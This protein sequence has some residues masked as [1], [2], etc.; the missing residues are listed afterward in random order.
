MADNEK[1]GIRDWLQLL[2]A[3]AWLLVFVK[4]PQMVFAITLLV[5]GGVFIAFNAMIFWATVVHKGE[6]PAVAPIFGGI[7]AGI[8]VAILPLAGGWKWAW[9][10]LLLDW[11]GLPMFL[12]YLVVR[13]SKV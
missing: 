2:A 12:Y 3:I 1:F 10:P 5:I 13:R 9:I 11:G 6:A 4:W 7:I 8:G